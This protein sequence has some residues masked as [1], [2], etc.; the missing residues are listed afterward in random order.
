MAVVRKDEMGKILKDWRG[1]MTRQE[2]ADK[3][4]AS[5]QISLTRQSLASYEHG[6]AMVPIATLLCIVKNLPGRPV[7]ASEAVRIWLQHNLDD[8]GWNDFRIDDENLRSSENPVPVNDERAHT[9]WEQKLLELNRIHHEYFDHTHEAYNVRL[10]R[11]VTQIASIGDDVL[12]RWELAAAGVAG[13]RLKG[14]AVTLR[15]KK[16]RIFVPHLDFEIDTFEDEVIQVSQKVDMQYLLPDTDKVTSQWRAFRKKTKKAIAK[17]LAADIHLDIANDLNMHAGFCLYECQHCG[18]KKQP[19]TVL[20]GLQYV[21]SSNLSLL[22]EQKKTQAFCEC[23]DE[24]WS[25]ASV[26]RG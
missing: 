13:Q 11:V 23:F 4:S 22:L 20:I 26:I 7:S 8:V 21:D 3:V 25:N 9:Y 15:L 5:P 17:T 19:S 10:E 1:E 16:I 14:P 2:L 6:Y 24:N 18:K 12:K